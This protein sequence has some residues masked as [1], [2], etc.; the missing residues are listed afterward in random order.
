MRIRFKRKRR[1]GVL[2][3]A[4]AVL[5]VAALRALPAAAE[6]PDEGEPPAGADAD[7]EKAS[8]EGVELRSHRPEKEEAKAV[9]PVSVVLGETES[10][11]RETIIAPSVE[12]AGRG[13]SRAAAAGLREVR[14]VFGNREERFKAW[15]EG[16]IV[17]SPGVSP[18][19]MVM[20]TELTTSLK[21]A[22]PREVKAGEPIVLQVTSVGNLDIE[23]DVSLVYPD[24]AGY[25]RTRLSAGD[26]IGGKER[27]QKVSFTT[28]PA[29]SGSLLGVSIARPERS[30]H[31]VTLWVT[32]R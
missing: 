30:E 13:V 2:P 7:A 24:G 21:L 14:S 29:D 5:A 28:W 17:S 11:R 16:E 25:D 6:E 3:L 22:C 20:L 18:A 12:G 31:S 26:K 9:T 15:A 27:V 8:V 4:A 19:G 32:V 10:G 1:S 23:W